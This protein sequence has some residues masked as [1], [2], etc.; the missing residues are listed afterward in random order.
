LVLEGVFIRRKPR[1]T[2]EKVDTIFQ[3]IRERF[4]ELL[5]KD[6]YPLVMI[7]NLKLY[8]IK[9]VYNESLIYLRVKKFKRTKYYSVE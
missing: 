8:I 4:Y 5:E 6:I 3:V 1:P 9:F 7:K 2:P